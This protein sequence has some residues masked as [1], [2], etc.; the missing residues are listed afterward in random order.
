MTLRDLLKLYYQH[1]SQGKM[2][3][4]GTRTSDLTGSSWLST[5]DVWLH[6][7]DCPR[8]S[9]CSSLVPSVCCMSV[10]AMS[11]FWSGLGKKKKNM[12]HVADTLK[13]EVSQLLWISIPWLCIL[14][15]ALSQGWKNCGWPIYEGISVALLYCLVWVTIIEWS[16]TFIH[17]NIY[18]ICELS[19]PAAVL[20]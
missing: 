20:W 14:K 3:Q 11:P 4:G 9:S 6:G 15:V 2:S 8:H 17:N 7:H 1:D 13:L 19:V 18:F 10:C 5:W 12:F 16:D